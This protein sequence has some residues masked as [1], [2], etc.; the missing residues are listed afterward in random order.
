[1]KTGEIRYSLLN[2]KTA[3]FLHYI[4]ITFFLFII[5]NQLNAQDI[6]NLHI[7]KVQEEGLTNDCILSINQD[8]NGFL[9]FGTKEGLFRYDGYIFKAFRN[10]PG[11]ST[12]LMGNSIQC[13]YPEKNNLWIGSDGGLSRIDINTQNIKNFNCYGLKVNTIL[14]KND[15]IFWVGTASGLFQFNKN[16]YLWTKVPGF[17]KST[18]INSLTDDHNGHLYVTTR[19]GFY[20]YSKLT[21][22]CKYYRPDLPTFPQGDKNAPLSF[23]KSLLDNQGNLWIGTWDAGLLRFNT[24]TEKIKTWFYKTDDLHFLPYKI[25]SDLLQD[26]NGNIWLA[27]KE[28]GLTIFCPSKNKFIN[29]PVE[30]AGESR[31]SGAVISLFRDKSG[32]FW[33]GTENGIVKYD[34]H[35]VHLSKTIYQLKTDTGLI[36]THFA[37]LTMLKEKDGL[38]W[39]GMYEGLFM[40][41]QKKGFIQDY[42]KILG[43][44][45]NFAVFNILKDKSGATWLSVKNMLVKVSEN[46]NNR[47]HPLQAEIFKSPDIKSSIYILYI[48]NENRIWIGTHS[49]GIFRFDPE[50]RKFISYHYNTMGP[51]S[52]INEIRAFCEL[53]KDS[54]LIGGMHTGLILLHTNTGRFEK[55]TW[56]N[57]N[58][59]VSDLTINELYKKDKDLWIGTDYYG[60]WATNTQFKNPQIITVNDG[61]P[62]MSVS[63]IVGDKQNNLWLLTNAGAVKFHI[64]DRK[65]TQFNKKDGIQSPD[66][67]TSIVID[68]NSNISIASKGCIYSFNPANFVKNT[69]PPEVSITDLRIFDKDYTIHK[70]E[71][72]RLNYNQ[73]Y[74]SFEY[75]ALNYTQS[76]LNKYAYKMDGLDKSWNIAGS[77]RY[78]SYAN[79]DEGT[80]VFNVKACN[81]EGIWNNTPTKLVLIVNPP[82]WHRWWFYLSLCVLVLSIIYIIYRYNM[83]QFKMRLQLRDNIARDL[84]DDIGSTL[85]SIN[86]FSKIALQK[87][88]TDKRSSSELLQ[89]ISDKSERTLDALSDIVWSINTRNDGLDNFLMKAREYLSEVLEAQCIPYDFSIDLEIEHLKIG[90]ASRK[91][92]YL[93]FKEAICNA[94]KYSGCTFIQI[95]LTRHKSVCKL[96]ISDNG[97]GFNINAVSSGNGLYNMGQRAKKMGADL[98]IESDE[99][100][101]TLVSLSFHI[102]R[103]R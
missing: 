33:I 27:N 17:E 31:I 23:S 30:W 28:G 75:V 100:K 24:K 61:L 60:L 65:I 74:F 4:I 16:N 63:T 85:S 3:W 81:N 79:L 38:W 11:D 98:Y 82:F 55:I 47:N 49:N 103:F 20:C 96:T 102:P 46:V 51:E 99:N 78:V 2:H 101:G 34:P 19:N 18:F 71:T 92:L 67:L 25:I 57:I 42:S 64:P 35:Y 87:I 36:Y 93:I 95:C 37:P 8:S 56:N 5:P 59:L 84:H 70:G 43:L 50:A 40:Y 89:K 44:P 48:D 12:T 52:K 13:L 77:R 80:Y 26:E 90:M 94:S 22:V 7:E 32:T 10:F 21:G 39:M 58:K 68:D 45:A 29:Y 62:S 6:S 1:M 97:K 72:I 76:R 86:I 88:S 91:E 9:W 14:K 41:D 73:N 66:G 54:L 53:S 69:H 83:N 15:S